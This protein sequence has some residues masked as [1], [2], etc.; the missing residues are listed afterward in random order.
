MLQPLLLLLSMSGTSLG[1]RQELFYFDLVIQ[2]IINQDTSAVL[3]NDDLFALAD[4]ALTLRRNGIETAAAGIT[5]YRHY[6][7]SITVVAADTVVGM[8]QAWFYLLAGFHG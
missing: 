7:Q 3:A 6:G 2:L 4:L 8:Q 1:S 5:Q